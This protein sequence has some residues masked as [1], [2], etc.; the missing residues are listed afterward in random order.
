MNFESGRH[1]TKSHLASVIKM[2]LVLKKMTLEGGLMSLKTT[3]H[4]EFLDDDT[5]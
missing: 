1:A 3:N 2:A 4:D 5:H